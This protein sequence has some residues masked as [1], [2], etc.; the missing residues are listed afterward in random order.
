MFLI[1]CIL[2]S[3][4]LNSF[5]VFANSENNQEQ[6]DQLDGILCESDESCYG[7]DMILEDGS[8]CCTDI[9]YCT[10]L[11][12]L[13]NYIEDQAFEEANYLEEILI[14]VESDLSIT[15]FEAKL[16]S[17]NLDINSLPSDQAEKIITAQVGELEVY[18]SEA[19]PKEVLE[20][21][22]VQEEKLGL[23]QNNNQDNLNF[24]EKFESEFFIISIV[25]VLFIIG[26]FIFYYVGRTKKQIPLTSESFQKITNQNKLLADFNILISR[27]V[28]YTTIRNILINKGFKQ[29]DIDAIINAHHSNTLNKYNL[30]K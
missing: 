21:Q 11:E 24:F 16:L 3:L 23:N 17:E 28:P 4:V 12:E 5:P 6:C 22:R 19:V 30:K 1:L 20:E 27:K 14:K 15:K 8:L 25:L 7:T 26:L 13:E 18:G 10:S 9:A 2:F 29:S